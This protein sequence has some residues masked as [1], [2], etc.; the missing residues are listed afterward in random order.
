M[1]KRL[2]IILSVVLFPMLYIKDFSIIISIASYGSFGL[3]L[4]MIFII[5]IFFENI[6]NDNLETHKEEI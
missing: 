5:Y 6:N 4:Y 3:Y 2:T 1:L